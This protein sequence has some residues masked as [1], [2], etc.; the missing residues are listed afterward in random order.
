MES[1]AE[2]FIKVLNCLSCASGARGGGEGMGGGK[3]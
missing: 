2:E 1:P 3:S